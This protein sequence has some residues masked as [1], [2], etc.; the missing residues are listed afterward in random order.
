MADIILAIKNHNYI[1][2]PETGCGQSLR[3]LL[4]T[5]FL[6]TIYGHESLKE[7]HKTQNYLHP[8]VL[9]HIKLIY[10]F[11]FVKASIEGILQIEI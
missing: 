1:F 4:N 5:E 8:L 9:R 3:S 11:L 7:N 6:D 2:I 10:L